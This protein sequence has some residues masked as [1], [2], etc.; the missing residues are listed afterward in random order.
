MEITDKLSLADYLWI[1]KLRNEN[2]HLMTGDARRISLWR[3]I[4][5]WMDQKPGIQLY[6]VRHEGRR[7]GYLL[8]REREA[9]CAYIT[10]CIAKEAQGE[11]IGRELVRFA[12]QRRSNLIADVLPSNQPSIRLHTRNGF[13]LESEREGIQRYVWSKS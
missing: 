5:F 3:Q 12:Q 7:A 10:E 13:V 9:G 8:L 4:R 2:R 6:I 1:R 11:G